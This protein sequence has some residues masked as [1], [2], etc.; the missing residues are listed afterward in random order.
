[1]QSSLL[2][3]PNMIAMS[4]P[5]RTI[6]DCNLS[7]LGPNMIAM[8]DNLL[9]RDSSKNHS[10]VTLGRISILQSYLVPIGK[11]CY[12][13]WSDSK[14]RLQSYLVP[15]LANIA[16]IFSPYYNCHYNHIWAPA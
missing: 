16:I 3:G 7:Q 6:Y 5:N 4:I 13:I 2:M 15:I 12:H 14:L 1:M 8:I 11:D 10:H 9:S